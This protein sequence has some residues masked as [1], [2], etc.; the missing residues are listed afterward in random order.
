MAVPH[1]EAHPA[2]SFTAWSPNDGMTILDEEEEDGENNNWTPLQLAAANGNAPLVRGLLQAG[3][4]PNAPPTGWYGKTALQVA[5]LNGHAEVVDALICAGAAVDAPGGNNGGRVALTLAAGA[6]QLIVVGRL[7]KAGAEL[8]TPPARY[9]GRTALQAAA[10]GGHSHVVT[11]LVALNGNVNAAPAHDYGRSALAAAAE[12]Q[13]IDIVLYLLDHGADVNGAISKYKGLSALQ[14]AAS[15][16]S[17]KLVKIML[18]A[19]ADV[20]AD[21]SHYGG[22]TA[23]YA[24]AEG[25]HTDV[26]KVLLEA[27]ADAASVGQVLLFLEQPHTQVHP[28]TST[29]IEHVRK[30]TMQAIGNLVSQLLRGLAITCLATTES[31]FPRLTESPFLRLPPELRNSIYKLALQQPEPASIR[32]LGKTESRQPSSQLPYHATALT[33]TCKLI[34]GEATQLFYAINTFIILCEHVNHRY[35]LLLL[36][37]F[38]DQIGQQ[39][40]SALRSINIDIGSFTDFYDNDVFGQLWL[41]AGLVG[42]EPQLKV[43]CTTPYEHDANITIELSLAM[44]DLKS[45]LE[46]QKRLFRAEMVA[47]DIDGIYGYEFEEFCKEIEKLADDMDVLR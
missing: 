20:D 7:L 27:G 44:H 4:D 6:G 32:R 24:A 28:K 37:D 13:H 45:S 1:E 43:Q 38:L 46:V 30:T 18:D 17:V 26:V 8:N 29:V 41:L 10:E 19:G 21:G 40:K 3:A 36:C 5:S 25:G 2:Y 34:R 31:L 23:L 11:R 35:K 16:G 47:T 12:G 15:T 9:I 14:A 33:R 22:C 42:L 39:N